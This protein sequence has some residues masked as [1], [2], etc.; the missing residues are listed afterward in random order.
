MAMCIY[1]YSTDK[2]RASDI[3]PWHAYRIQ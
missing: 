2:F 3:H 1:L